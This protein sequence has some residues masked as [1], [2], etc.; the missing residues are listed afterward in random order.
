MHK[1]PEEGQWW[2]KTQE[3]LRMYQYPVSAR[4]GKVQAIKYFL[5]H[6]AHVQMN[7]LHVH[8]HMYVLNCV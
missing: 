3:E 1:T 4:K 6:N 5:V 7:Q 8:D 2:P